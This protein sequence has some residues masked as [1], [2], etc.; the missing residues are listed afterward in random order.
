MDHRGINFEQLKKILIYVKKRCDKDEAIRGW[1]DQTTGKQLFYR[2]LTLAQL[3][4]WV[5]QPLCV[6]HQCSYVEAVAKKE[7]KKK[8]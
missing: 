7:P 2:S 8:L 3:Q 5:I 4:H 6:R 1:Y